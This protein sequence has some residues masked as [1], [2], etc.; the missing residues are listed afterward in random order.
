MTAAPDPETRARFD[1]APW[2][3]IARDAMGPAG[4]V[5]TML[6]EAEQRLYFWLARDWAQGA[7]A[8]VDLGCFAGGSTARLAEGRRQAGHA[9]H[10]HAYDRFTASDRLKARLLYPAGI[11]PFDGQDI[12]PLAR[13]L[14]APWDGLVRLHPGEIEDDL[15]TGQPIEVLTIDAA[16]S[17]GAADAIA[18]LFFPS[19]IPGAS[20]VVQQDYFHWRQPWVAAQME[21]L[22]ECFVPLAVCPGA[23]AV[24]LCTRAPDAA[25]LARAA[26][27][28]LPDAGLLADLDAARRR[29]ARFGRDARFARMRAA[30]AAN[31]GE[32]VAWRFRKP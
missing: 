27:D 16:K 12:L 17:A 10:V 14:L 6:S 31:P 13:R 2:D 18:G 23:T 8:I 28:G 30:I 21:R 20:V 19:L 1:A 9:P 29:M 22:A 5:P 11:A 7:G 25:T 32:R 26:C 24:F 4:T 3:R 15:W